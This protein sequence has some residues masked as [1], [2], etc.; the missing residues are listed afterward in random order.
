MGQ[1]LEIRES[2]ADDRAAIDALYP[3]AFPDEDLLPLVADIL[4]ER[5]VTLSLVAVQA[6]RLV[7][8]IMFTRCSVDGCTVNSALLAPLA[9]APESQRQGIGT[10]LVRA[11]LQWLGQDGIETVYV[12]GDPA[13]YGRLGFCR[14]RSV[15]P[16]YPLPSEWADAWQ[17]LHLAEG[18]GNVN[19]TLA[20]PAF[21][22]DPALW[23][24]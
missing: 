19:G 17:T 12:L 1:D 15:S 16:P 9:V 24:G 23:S 21:W 6:G 3:R 20:L 11:G 14:E 4:R 18:Q 10:S 5:A 2:V 22:L 8:N 13:Y 7:G